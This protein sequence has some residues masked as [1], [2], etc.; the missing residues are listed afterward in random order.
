MFS[1]ILVKIFPEESHVNVTI[2][3]KKVKWLLKQ[4]S[5]K[6]QMIASIEFLLRTI[7]FFMLV[8]IHAFVFVALSWCP[9]VASTK[10]IEVIFFLLGTYA[11]QSFSVAPW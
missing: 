1:I 4:I 7:I 5:D 10:V 8:F 6:I 9:Q 11:K 3:K 2:I